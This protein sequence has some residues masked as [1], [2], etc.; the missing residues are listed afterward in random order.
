MQ[1]KVIETRKKAGKSE[2]KVRCPACSKPRWIAKSNYAQNSTGLCLKCSVEQ[3]RLPLGR[4]WRGMLT[5]IS[6]ARVGN[7]R[8]VYTF[9][10][11]CGKT[12][13][14]VCHN[15]MRSCGCL[16]KQP[17]LSRRKPD[18]ALGLGR[19]FSVYRRSA[20]IRGLEFS[21]DRAAFEKLVLS[22][23]AYCG[24]AQS[25]TLRINGRSV[26]VCFNGIDRIQSTKGY[27]AE[28]CAPC[29]ETCNRAKS[30]MP[31]EK[32]LSWA[33]RVAQHNQ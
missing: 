24:A 27:A 14:S 1:L 6:L 20:L 18:H 19:V 22:D 4:P 29:C 9:K 11:E 10:C 13:D 17:R 7:G 8:T 21:L 12:F 28:N 26:S 15:S 33:R 5:P 16:K 31:L 23:C 32:F 2:V 30:D 25:K 3:T